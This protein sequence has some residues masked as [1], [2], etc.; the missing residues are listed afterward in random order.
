[1]R[2]PNFETI[3]CKVTVVLLALAF[4]AFLPSRR[5]GAQ[6]TTASLGGQVTDTQG[7]AIAGARV[8]VIADA[9]GVK[10]RTRTN[11]SGEWRVTSLPIGK[12]GFSVASAGFKTLVHPSI[13]LEIESQSTINV[14]LHVG[15]ASQRVVV[16]GSDNLLNTTAAVS[17]TVLTHSELEEL[18]TIS[19]APTE[20]A[21]LAPGLFM[22][23]SSG[24][25]PH[26][27]SNNSE[28]ALTANG[29]GSGTNA[30]N[31]TLDGATNSI[32]SNGQIAFI[33]PMD[34]VSE[35][36]I[37]TNA[38]DASIGRTAAGTVNMSLKSGSNKFHGDLYE[39]NQNNFLNADYTQFNATHRPTPVVRFNEYGGT[40]GGPVWIPRVYDGKSKGTF[41]FF[42][43]DGLRNITPASTGFLSLPTAEE[44]QG[45]FS[46]SF[47]VVNG[48]HYPLVPYDPLTVDPATGERVP[49]P[50]QIIPPSR[51]SPLAKAIF[52][53]MP[54]PNTPNT[55]ENSDSNDYIVNDPS[56]ARFGSWAVRVDQSW[57]NSDHSYFEWRQNAFK[58]TTADVFGPNSILAGDE[59]D[60]FNYG[61]TANNTW[62]ITPHLLLTTNLNGTAWETTTSYT[63]SRVDPTQFGVSSALASNQFERGLPLISGAVPGQNVGDPGNGYEN[64]YEW[65]ANASLLQTLGKHELHYGMQYLL[66]QETRGSNSGGAGRF[67]FTDAWTD[68]NPN[69]TAPPGT[70]WSLP[71]FLLGMPASGSIVNNA[72]PFWTQPYIGFYVED[73][74]H[75]TPHLT[76]NLGLRWD[77]Q[78][79]MTEKH[80][81]FFTV[82]DPTANITPVTNYAQPRYANLINGAAE[83]A[84]IVLLQ[85]QRSDVANFKALGAIKYAGVNGTS[86]YVTDPNYTYWQPRIGFAYQVHP[87]TVISGGFGRFTQSNFVANH[88]NQL[89]YNA[90]TPFVATNNNFISAADTLNNPFPNGMVPVTGNTLGVLTGV[91]TVT[92]FFTPNVP[93]QNTYDASLRVQ[94]QLGAYVLNIAG[95]YDHTTGL[96]VGIS[97]D[98][99]SLTAW[100]AALDPEFDSS[101]RPVNTLPGNVQVANPFYGAPYITS[102]FERDKTTAAYRLL[103]PNP[104]VNGMSENEYI[105]TSTHNAL[106]VQLSRRMTHGFSLS[107]NFTWSKQ[108][109]KD[110]YFTPPEVSVALHREISPNDRRFQYVFAPIYRL[111]FGRGATFGSDVS[112]P[113][114]ELVG[115]WEIVGIYSFFSGTPVKFGT[116]SEFFEGGDPSLGDK[117]SASKWFDTS[118]F[119]A[120]PNRSTSVA[121]LSEYPGW[122]RV[123]SLPGASWTPA[124]SSD[125]TRNGVYNDFA[126]WVSN[127]PTTFGS[128]RNPYTTKLDVGL[129]KTFSLYK[130]LRLQLRMDAFNALNHPRS[131]GPDT[132]PNDVHFGW[133][134][135]SPLPTQTNTPR[136]IQLE[137][138]FYF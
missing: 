11:N 28:S 38:Y 15:S 71:S 49:F 65:E 19:N 37:T 69:D 24:G 66:Q 107:T 91:G 25:T 21:L 10:V 51:I 137:G 55:G 54:L 88:G 14:T 112:R 105:G 68:P 67:T 83:N 72:Q 3:S 17:G 78:L 86:R 9:T 56:D 133:L 106:Q 30:M 2:Y 87:H 128:V 6:V 4:A 64:D 119:K 16:N 34:A 90:T 43:Y 129:R 97:D 52:A 123:E 89:G 32:N 44:R 5:A 94:Q 59:L 1:M 103:R 73:D 50:G 80:N 26:L 92:S 118:K 23:H 108:M 36:R 96:E 18:P 117:K 98:N 75:A 27:Y 42:S 76:V 53:A 121:Q 138:K 134:N 77:A 70:E 104:I 13:R 33:P 135:G 131:G 95:V 120:F 99:P 46:Q 35:V 125:R 113:L 40:V 47:E 61:L 29:S 111:P 116:N 74:W 63:S 126:T 132:N 110:E 101:G 127:N 39:I 124:S 22:G 114:N 100:H 60:R 12:Y 115:G 20:L 62:T 79:G 58:Q 57:N 84:G 82:F 81:R 136:T 48:V 109:D 31:Y 8:T 93:R 130:L 85:Q 7:R 102:G 122:T 41:F 45:N